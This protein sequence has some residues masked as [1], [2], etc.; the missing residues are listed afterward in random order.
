MFRFFQEP[1]NCD[2]GILQIQSPQSQPTFNPLP[3]LP[4]KPV[5]WPSSLST[6]TEKV[7]RNPPSCLP[8]PAKEW[9]WAA[10][11][12]KARRWAEREANKRSDPSYTAWDLSHLTTSKNSQFWGIFTWWV[13]GRRHLGQATITAK[14]LWSQIKEAYTTH[15]IN[16]SAAR[17]HAHTLTHTLSPSLLLRH[18]PSARPK[19]SPR[20]VGFQL[21][22][23]LTSLLSFTHQVH[24]FTLS[25]VQTTQVFH[26]KNRKRILDSSP[27][28]GIPTW[29][30]HPSPFSRICLLNIFNHKPSKKTSKNHNRCRQGKGVSGAVM[31]E[32]G[33]TQ[34][35]CSVVKF[36]RRSTRIGQNTPHASN[37]P[38]PSFLPPQGSQYQRVVSL[39]HYSSFSRSQAPHSLKPMAWRT[40]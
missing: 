26:P 2:C 11:H 3:I 32:L 37:A 27:N 15:P 13:E 23:H 14:F 5:S 8:H 19:S 20:T 17:A 10:K 39:P 4:V 38:C 7:S 28:L 22:F 29:C 12:L 35:G 30:L 6:I 21:S 24:A 33:R 16:L 34:E 9:R 40:H 1:W 25:L 36:N 18:L 31:T